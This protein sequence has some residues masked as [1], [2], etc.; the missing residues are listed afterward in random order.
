VRARRRTFLAVLG[1]LLLLVGGLA[2][3]AG[4]A[5]LI[6]LATGRYQQLTTFGWSDVFVGPALVGV[7]A[8]ILVKL[9]RRWRGAESYGP[10]TIVLA[11]SRRSLIW[12]NV[13]LTLVALIALAIGLGNVIEGLRNL[14]AGH[15]FTGHG[16]GLWTAFLGVVG[17]GF[18][19]G[20]AIAWVENVRRLD[21]QDPLF[22]ADDE[23]I[24]CASGRF[25]WRDIDRVLQLTEVTGSGENKTVHRS[26]AFVL[27][28]EATPRR[29]ERAYLEEDAALAPFGF[30]LEITHCTN[31]ANAALTAY[32]HTPVKG[33]LSELLPPEQSEAPS[34]NPPLL[35][36]PASP[37]ESATESPSGEAP[38]WPP[39]P[40][41]ADPTP[42]PG[43]A[44]GRPARVEHSFARNVRDGLLLALGLV[45]MLGGALVIIGLI[46]NQTSSH[47]KSS[48]G[49]FVGG[50]IFGLL[51]VA[52]GVAL[53]RRLRRKRKQPNLA[54]SDPA[55]MEP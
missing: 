4:V 50:L 9:H 23:G 17:L 44:V 16:G 48:V 42:P 51:V 6:A 45:L 40:N 11:W 14:V 30:V 43:V 22:M 15:G 13:F 20:A 3:I 5:A 34:P 32:G 19:L 46:G 39:P 27:S 28:E 35:V 12:W 21:H 36:E 24:E 37:A 31:Q 49:G 54:P 26:L 52:G 25:S 8:L 29:V 38:F 53:I 10:G 47:Q 1:F 7:G 41:W 55:I 18:G 33:E 2:S